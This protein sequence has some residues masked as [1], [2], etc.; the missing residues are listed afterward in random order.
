MAPSTAF[1]KSVLGIFHPRLQNL[2]RCL[3]L[4]NKPKSLSAAKCLEL[5]MLLTADKQYRSPT[6]KFFQK[7]SKEKQDVRQ[8]VAKK[9]SELSELQNSCKPL[10]TTTLGNKK[11]VQFVT[12]QDMIKLFANFCCVCLWHYAKKSNVIQR[13]RNVSDNYSPS[14]KLWRGSPKINSNSTIYQGKTC[15]W[16]TLWVSVISRV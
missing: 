11:P 5:T 14:S 9:Q 15:L 16:K 13:R 1:H 8:A 10:A 7:L 4:A 6:D 2:P 3:P 12:Q